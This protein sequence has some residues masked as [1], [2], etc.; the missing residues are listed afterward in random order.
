L[1]N[2]EYNGVSKIMKADMWFLYENMFR[3]RL[4]EVKVIEAW[5]EGKIS[6]EMHLSKGEEAIVAGTVLQL[7]DGDAMALDHRGTA[8]MVM[9]GVD[10]VLLF[11]EFLGHP[12]GLCAGKGG[13]MHLFSKEHLA[14][15]SGIVGASGPAAVGFALAA[16]YLRPGKVALAFFGEGAMNQGMLL[17]AMNLA[18]V[19]KLPVVFICKDSKWAI[20]TLSASVTSGSLVE[21]ALSFGMASMKVDGNDVEAVWNTAEEAIKRA[22]A[23]QGPTF[24]HATCSHPEGHFL[25]DPLLRIA[26]HPVKEMKKVAG[27]LL[28]SVTKVKGG[29]VIERTG[30]L[31]TVT[32]LI[33]KTTKE[34]VFDQKDPL[35]VVRSKLEADKD[36]LKKLEESVN[37]EIQNVV[38]NV[39]TSSDLKK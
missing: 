16:Q 7:Q 10:L 34:Q 33:G 32:S 28:K 30:G 25:G 9:R 2:S 27:P 36:R 15:S 20:T 37:E 24:L 5:N 13:H 39:L 17:E 31:G 3:S 4:F 8:P 14:A 35:K 23:K 18:M 21:R 38:N 11:R 29:S 26:R 6:G 12:N 19:W 1:Y 22:R